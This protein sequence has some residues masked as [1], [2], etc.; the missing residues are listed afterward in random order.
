MNEPNHQACLEE[1][2]REMAIEHLLFA[3]L[4]FLARKYPELPDELDSSMSHLWDRGPE[5]RDDGRVREIAAK[6]VESLR[7][8][9]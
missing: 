9:A 6:F 7:R 5:P 4:R 2:R 8:E 3:A 1:R